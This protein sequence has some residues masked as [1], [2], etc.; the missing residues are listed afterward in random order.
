MLL[1]GHYKKCFVLIIAVSRTRSLYA[2]ANGVHLPNKEKI[3]S[4][5]YGNIEQA[6]LL[7]V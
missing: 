6:H 4:G 3:E 7:K 1:R 5:E 2:C